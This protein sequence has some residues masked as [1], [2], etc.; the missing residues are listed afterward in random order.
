MPTSKSHLLS[1]P[2]ELLQSIYLHSF[3]PHLPHASPIL[4]A[5]LSTPHIYRLTF[6]RAFWNGLPIKA[7]HGTY[8]YK[9]GPYV[10]ELFSPLPVPTV[11]SGVERANGLARVE[12]QEIVLRC[13]WCSLYNAKRWLEAVLLAVMKDLPGTLGLHLSPIER[14]SL[15]SYLPANLQT[16]FALGLDNS[17]SSLIYHRPFA[18]ALIATYHGPDPRFSQSTYRSFVVMPTSLLVL[19]SYVLTGHSEWTWEKVNG[20]KFL[21]SYA[22]PTVKYEVGALHEGMKNAIVQRH[23]DALLTLVWFADR[24]AEFVRSVS[25]KPFDHTRANEEIPFK[26]PAELFRLVARRGLQTFA[27]TLDQHPSCECKEKETKTFIRLFMLLL[28]ADA[29]SL[30]QD[31]PDILAWA[32]RL[33]ACQ[34][35]DGTLAAFAQCI[36]DWGS[37][38]RLSELKSDS[39]GEMSGEPRKVWWPRFRNGKLLRKR[40]DE[41]MAK[42]FEMILGE[43]EMTFAEEV[44]TMEM[45]KKELE[46]ME[47]EKT[48][49]ENMEV[50]RT[51]VEK[52]EVEAQVEEDVKRE[53]TA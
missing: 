42:K 8:S 3:S 30:P 52:T 33:R 45:K 34:D 29:E 7:F 39:Y 10:C 51:E 13:R 11:V 32:D 48:K 9:P 49:V 36:S 40:S 1:L 53:E 44:E 5:A 50:D 19:P 38:K 47:V 17:C 22:D 35:S 24:R 4:A 16:F 20:L 28:R 37:N 2:P 21:C 31:D 41:E 14:A 26:V 46:K 23:H 43:E 25:E 18:T 6:L 15:D 12:L 27:A